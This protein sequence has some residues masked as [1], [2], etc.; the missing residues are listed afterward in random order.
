MEHSSSA[1]MGGKR[2]GE[3][4]TSHPTP[5]GRD[6]HMAEGPKDRGDEMVRPEL[7]SDTKRWTVMVKTLGYGGLSKQFDLS[8]LSFFI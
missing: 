4:R 1:E 3:A 6:S 7:H 2:T 8:E 5:E